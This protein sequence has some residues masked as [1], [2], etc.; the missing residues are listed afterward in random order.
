MQPD[1]STLMKGT[2]GCGKNNFRLKVSR[3][4]FRIYVSVY[5]TQPPFTS[6]ICGGKVWIIHGERWYFF[7][8]ALYFTLFL[9]KSSHHTGIL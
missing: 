3:K 9:N 8:T 5:N 6:Q 2:L 4:M 7:E 1:A